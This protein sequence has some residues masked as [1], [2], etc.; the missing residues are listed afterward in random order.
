MKA[1]NECY[2]YFKIV[3]DFDP[4]AVTHLLGIE[5]FESWKI[6][7]LRANGSRFDFA[8][9]KTGLCEKYDV[10]VEHQMKKTLKELWGKVDLL[11]RIRKEND[12]EFYLEVVPTVFPG[13][14]TP[15]LAPTLDI[16]DFCHATRTKID[17]DLYVVDSLE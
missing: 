4:D 9:W 12:V 16:M 10:Y 14:S 7:D 5:P 3:G 17:I 13:E 11:N 1:R 8:C 2:T 6:G 15:C